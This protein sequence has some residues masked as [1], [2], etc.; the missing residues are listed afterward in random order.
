MENKN[1][2][3]DK[4][5]LNYDITKH[6]DMDVESDVLNTI[7]HRRTTKIPSHRIESDFLRMMDSDDVS[8]EEMEEHSSTSHEGALWNQK[9]FPDLN[10]CRIV[11]KWFD[12]LF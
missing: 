4:G 5:I 12:S 10:V 7:Q 9:M 11:S 3:N 8:K 1:G 6:E 2:R